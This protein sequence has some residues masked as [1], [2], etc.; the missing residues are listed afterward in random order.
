ML[1]LLWFLFFQVFGLLTAQRCFRNLDV[2]ERV[3]LGSVCGSTA[4]MW[5]P[6]PF[7]F[8]FGFGLTAHLCALAVVG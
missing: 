6:I 1:G 3:L 7:S 5:L 4:A 2:L 8:L